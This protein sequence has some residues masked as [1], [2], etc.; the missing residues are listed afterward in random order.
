MHAHDRVG[1]DAP[2]ASSGPHRYGAKEIWAKHD[3]LSALPGSRVGRHQRPRDKVRPASPHRLV[4][5]RVALPGEAAPVRNSERGSLE[6]DQQ[7]RRP[8]RSRRA[9]SRQRYRG[10]SRRGLYHVR[11]RPASTRLRRCCNAAAGA[12]RLNRK[13]CVPSLAIA[14]C[15]VWPGCGPSNAFTHASLLIGRRCL[16]EHVV[17]D[18]PV[19]ARCTKRGSIGLNRTYEG[20]RDLV[21]VLSRGTPG[22]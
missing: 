10:Q 18:E 16:D 13:F 21:S 8:R 6:V 3:H 22:R 17:L 5:P 12:L 1:T 9:P 15:I 19:P 2:L 11:W 4:G 20:R 7:D 14:N